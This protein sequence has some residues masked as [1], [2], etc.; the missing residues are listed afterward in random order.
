MLCT[1]FFRTGTVFV[2]SLLFASWD[3][4]SPTILQIAAIA[5][6]G[7]GRILEAFEA[8]LIFDERQATKRAV[9]PRHYDRRRQ[10]ILSWER[11]AKTSGSHSI[12]MKPM[13][14]LPM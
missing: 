9:S 3:A 4:D 10:M 6:R 11:C 2:G 5:V 14:P 8:K 7:N 13:K 12:L 1:Q